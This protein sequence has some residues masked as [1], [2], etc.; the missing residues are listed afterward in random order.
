MTEHHVT[1]S[2]NEPRTIRTNP[3]PEG[4]RNIVRQTSL[5]RIKQHCLYEPIEIYELENKNNLV[6]GYWMGL[7]MVGNSSVRILFKAHY[8]NDELRVIAA[9]ALNSSKARPDDS[10]VAD[11]MR[12]YCNLMGGAIKATLESAGL[13]T[14]VSLPLVTRGFDEV[15]SNQSVSVNFYEDV[16]QLVCGDGRITCAVQMD[17]MNNEPLE[18]IGMIQEQQQANDADGEIEFL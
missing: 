6:F 9:E 3:I 7:I 18:L 13:N 12:E 5:V 4:F 10:S 15:F 16:W 2:Q 8:N 11:F 1:D 17:V 14:G